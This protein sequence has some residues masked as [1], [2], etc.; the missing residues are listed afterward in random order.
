MNTDDIDNE[1]IN[2]LI[3]YKPL[4]KKIRFGSH[5]DG[6]YIIVD[7]YD[8]DLYISCG[9]GHDISFDLDFYNYKKNI[10]YLTFDG[11]V[12]RPSNMPNDIDFIKQNISYIKTTE[13]TNLEEY[14][15]DHSDVFLKMDIE[16]H[17]WNWVKN[18]NKLSSL[19]QIIIEAHGLF[20]PSWMEIG[21]YEYSSILE[22]LILLNKTHYLVHFHGNNAGG[23]KHI[24]GIKYP[25][26]CELTYIR[27][28]DCHI[29]GLNTDILP[30]QNLDFPNYNHEDFSFNSYPF[31]KK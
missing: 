11:T 28:S 3:L 22:S 21:K 26:V 25:T 8:Y 14:I 12:N 18:T 13:T 9:I 16:G 6:G 5:G 23:I 30:I 2:N 20:D 1:I 10:K 15:S 29:N 27:K 24:D 31:I 17:E 4:N 7:G 19:K